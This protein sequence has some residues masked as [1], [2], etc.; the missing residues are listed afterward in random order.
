MEAAGQRPPLL[1]APLGHRAWISGAPREGLGPLAGPTSTLPAPPHIP[2]QANHQRSLPRPQ[3]L[4][5]RGVWGGGSGLLPPCALSPPSFPR[6]GVSPQGAGQRV[7]VLPASSVPSL[8][9]ALWGWECGGAAGTLGSPWGLW[10]VGFPG[11]R[12][13]AF[14]VLGEPLSKSTT[15]PPPTIL[16][17]IASLDCTDLG[18]I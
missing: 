9:H 7:A 4:G 11:D 1:P 16:F 6:A 8:P 12:D 18:H 14:S 2:L 17:P 15:T 5:C 10:V 13:T 3:P